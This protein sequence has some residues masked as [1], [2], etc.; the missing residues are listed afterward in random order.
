MA[1]ALVS[2][3]ITPEQRARLTEK[4]IRFIPVTDNIMQIRSL[5]PGLRSDIRFNTF[6]MMYAMRHIKNTDEPGTPVY[7]MVKR[8]IKNRLVLVG[9]TPDAYINAL[10]N[11]IADIIVY[12]WLKPIEKYNADTEK[13]E[14]DTKSFPLVFA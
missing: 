14:H 11:D 2:K 13:I 9:T 12:A 1:I 3:G 4:G 10:V 5:P 6:A 8:Y 7:E